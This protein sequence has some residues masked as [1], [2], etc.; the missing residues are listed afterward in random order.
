M[1][2]NLLSLP[3]INIDDVFEGDGPGFIEGGQGG[4]FPP[5]K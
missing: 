4:H 1:F 2:V 3:V 5:P